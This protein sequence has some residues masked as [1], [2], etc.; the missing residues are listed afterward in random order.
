[1]MNV[2]E[3]FTKLISDSKTNE[4]MIQEYMEQHTELIPFAAHIL[5]HGIHMKSVISKFPIGKD[6]I[7]DFA[8]LTKSTICWNLVLVEIEDSNKKMFI[9]RSET[10]FTAQFN[11]AYSQIQSWKAHIERDDCEVKKQI[12]KIRKPLEDNIVRYKYVL[13]YGRDEEL[14]GSDRRRQ[15]LLQKCSDDIRVMTYDSLISQLD[16]FTSWGIDSIIVLK[17]KG[18]QNFEIKRLPD[19]DIDTALFAYMRA[20]DLVVSKDI[21]NQLINLDYQ[22]DEWE[23]GEFLTINNKYTP[24]TYKTGN[25]LI[26]ELMRNL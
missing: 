15:M 25:K 22:I 1:M 24:S 8:F 16:T 6:Y 26:D 21:K 10:D 2:K 17:T 19:G 13:V 4:S 23:K 18:S 3:E 7:T 12:E 9:T 20:C 14:K 5:N 11:H